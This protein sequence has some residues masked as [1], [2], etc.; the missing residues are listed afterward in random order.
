[1]FTTAGSTL[2]TIAAKVL[3]SCTGSGIARGVAPP[4]TRFLAAPTRP[5][6]TVPINI[7]TDRVTTTS[8]VARTLRCLAQ[9]IN[10]RSE[11]HTLELQSPMYLVC[12][13]LLEKKNM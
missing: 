6:T 1:M 7:P 2:L 4:P 3:D 11:E 5:E 10:S 8:K 9:T 13:L 12:R